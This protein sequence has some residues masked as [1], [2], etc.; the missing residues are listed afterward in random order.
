MYVCMYDNEFN[1]A[2]ISLLWHPMLCGVQINVA[3]IQNIA[4]LLQRHVDV[5]A[6]WLLHNL[7]SDG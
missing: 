5:R 6:V 7:T 4:L 2:A 3:G 1:S